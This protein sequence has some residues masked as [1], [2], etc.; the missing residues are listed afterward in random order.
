MKNTLDKQKRYL[1]A[2]SGVTGI[3]CL[4][5]LV[6]Q[7]LECVLMD[8][9]SD[10]A[11]GGAF[12]TEFTDMPVVLGDLESFDYKPDDVLIVSPGIGLEAAFIQTAKEKGVS[13]SSDIALFDQLCDKPV[14]AI[15]GSNGKSTVTTLVAQMLC[16]IG[17]KSVAIGNIGVP[18]LSVVED[19]SIDVFVIELSSFQLERIDGLTCAA[20]TILNLSEDHMDRYADFEAYIN[21]K[22]SIYKQA[23]NCIY[24]RDDSATLAQ[25]TASRLISFGLAQ[26][27][28]T[29]NENNLQVEDQLLCTADSLSIK[30]VH[31]QLNVLAAFAL[32]EALCA[33]IDYVYDRKALVE[34]AQSF[35]GLAHRCEFVSRVAQ[36]D[37]INDS[38]ATNVGA[39]LAALEGLCKSY[40]HIYILIGGEDKASDFS[41][42]AQKVNEVSAKAIAYGADAKVI[43][44]AFAK[45]GQSVF[46]AGN[47]QAAFIHA[48]EQANAGD[49]ILLAPACAS[50]D[51][52]KNFMARGDAFK[53]MTLA[54]A[55]E[56][57]RGGQ[58]AG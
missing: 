54:H 29:L 21:A 25:S 49:A 8:T 51:E 20:A 22:Q 24:N 16:A 1:I 19:D 55:D 41:P 5:F 52:F 33:S 42:L 13:I 7:G 14:V 58:Y 2:G 43:V 34:A 45:A 12:Y 23:A 47:L 37:F 53:A 36:V 18:V 27:E 17:L 6:A 48:I 39:S 57:R 44:D 10:I 35:K 26:A 15:T 32:C 11:F 3:A 50:F 56:N 9:R 40:K 4:R 46:Q 38:K 28:Y 30:G 31:N